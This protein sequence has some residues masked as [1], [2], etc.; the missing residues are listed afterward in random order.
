[1][2]SQKERFGALYQPIA[3]LMSHSEA[4]VEASRCLYCH[5]APCI[6]ACPT[7][8]DVPTFIRQIAGGNPHGAARTILEQNILGY[9]CGQVCPTEELCEGA[10]VLHGTEQPPIEIGRLQA[11]AVHAALTDG[12][13]FFEAGWLS[14]A[15]IAVVGAGPAGLACA[16]E[17]TRL[18]HAVTVF[19]AS[20][21]AGGLNAFGVAPYKLDE[22]MMNRE[23]EF[24]HQIGFEIRLNQR[25]TTGW[26]Y[27][28]GT[29]SLSWLEAAFDAVFMAIGKGGTRPLVLPGADLSG[30]WLASDFIARLRTAP[31]SL[32]AGRRVVVI[33]GGNTAMDAA[34]ESA[35]LGADVTVAYRG[36]KTDLSAYAEEVSL[37]R[38]EGV[39][40]E[41][42]I[43]PTEILASPADTD[44]VCAVRCRR[45]E[46]VPNDDPSI[47]LPCDT[48]ILA[49]GQTP[50]TD[51]LP[52]DL[53]NGE[54]RLAVNDNLQF[55][56][57]PKLFA[58][59]DCVNGGREVVHAVAHGRDGARA[60]H[61]WLLAHAEAIRRG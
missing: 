9:A 53:S 18:G 49:T 4:V 50:G 58:G 23:I 37:A 52:A 51:W 7:A 45:S 21:R 46:V 55:E 59:G 29:V 25:V 16:H 60:I 19:E 30:V 17:L 12:Q 48:V 26:G 40:F 44:R 36:P 10:C 20:D 28:P 11:F 34:V 15:R 14:G 47:L 42:G 35:R 8:I 54:G 3:P 38:S 22:T 33:G 27:G 2:T 43:Y 1:M 31:G 6:Q 57:R 32:S 24:I 61:R 41:F 56:H 5:D 39:R 13:R